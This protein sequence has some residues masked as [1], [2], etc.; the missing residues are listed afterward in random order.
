MIVQPQHLAAVHTIIKELSA[1]DRFEHQVKSSLKDCIE[2]VNAFGGALYF[3]HRQARKLRVHC[4]YS[5]TRSEVISSLDLSEQDGVAGR[6]F[7]QMQSEITLLEAQECPTDVEFYDL[8]QSASAKHLITTPIQIGKEEPLGVIQ[9]LHYSSQRFNDDD[10]MFLESIA[11]IIALAY[12]NSLLKEENH[13]GCQ[14]LGMGKVAHDIK[15]LAYALEANVHVSDQTIHELKQYVDKNDDTLN[16]YVDS[17]NYLYDEITSSVDRVK[18]YSSLISD[19]S[20]GKRLNPS[21]KLA[22]MAQSIQLGAAYLES[23]GRSHHVGFKYEIQHNAPPIRHDEM[24]VSRIVQNLV[25]NAIRAT[26]QKIVDHPRNYLQFDP[27][28]EFAIYEELTVRYAF[29]N[30]MHVLQVIDSG[31]GMSQ[32]MIAQILQGSAMSQ[33]QQHSGS[34]WG[35]KIVLELAASH[36]AKVDINSE[37]G[38]GTTFSIVFPPGT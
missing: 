13:R 24:Y 30:N 7:S 34:G 18:R 31:S 38:Q 10:L 6:V 15:N 25:S 16:S 12:S 8:G 2:A 5:L 26:Y 20:S 21:L 22:P 29:E 3:H 36:H 4:L 33:W 37:L 11:G 23:E 19:L 35:T 14:L 32:Q 1:T 27:E 9:L 28:D 17:I